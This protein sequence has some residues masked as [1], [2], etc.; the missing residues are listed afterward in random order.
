[1]QRCRRKWFRPSGGGGGPKLCGNAAGGRGVAAAITGEGGIGEQEKRSK[2]SP[3]S[4][5]PCINH[6]APT[7]NYSSPV[8]LP[9]HTSASSSSKTSSMSLPACRHLLLDGAEPAPALPHSPAAASLA[10]PPGVERQSHDK[11]RNGA[12]SD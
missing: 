3:C 6:A 8:P 11:C 2:R 12:L 10:P 5:V 4:P 1:V 9:A 7:T